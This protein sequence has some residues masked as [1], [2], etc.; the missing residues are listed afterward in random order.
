M[1][2]INRPSLEDIP[3]F[4]KYDFD[5][6]NEKCKIGSKVWSSSDKLYDLLKHELSLLTK[7]HCSFCDG[8]PLNNTS[9]T[10]IEHYYPKSIY[11]EKTYEWENLFLACDK[12]QSFAHSDNPFQKTLKMDEIDYFFESYFWF[13]AESGEVKILENMDEQNTFNARNFLN[14]YGINKS[15]ERLMARR[16]KYTDLIAIFKTESRERDF[17]PYRFV[18]DSALFHATILNSLSSEKN[19]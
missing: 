10:T 19:R 8:F 15:P 6:L 2:K 12:C 1:E 13:D 16:S 7:A 17:E 14:R 5:A 9:K 11:K 4:S 3:S 18:F